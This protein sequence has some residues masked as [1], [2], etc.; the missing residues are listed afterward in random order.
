[1]HP[2]LFCTDQP[3]PFPQI[4]HLL[5]SFLFGPIQT[6]VWDW[7]SSWLLGSLALGRQGSIIFASLAPLPSPSS[8]MRR[9]LCFRSAHSPSPLLALPWLPHFLL[10][11]H[12]CLAL[13]CPDRSGNSTRH[14]GHSPSLFAFSPP[15]LCAMN[16]QTSLAPRILSFFSLYLSTISC[17]DILPFLIFIH[18]LLDLRLASVPRPALLTIDPRKDSEISTSHHHPCPTPQRKCIRAGLLP[19]LVESKMSCHCALHCTI[20]PTMASS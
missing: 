8:S 11:H 14:S 10:V 20:S 3:A 1:M 18:R 15:L 7:I 17:L 12:R 19:F 5:A 2:C 16:V 4:F 13:V 6:K 9:R